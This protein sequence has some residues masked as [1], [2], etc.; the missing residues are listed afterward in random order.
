MEILSG[1]I[2]K[3]R[4]LDE[5]GRC[6]LE[7]VD[8]GDSAQGLIDIILAV[9]KEIVIPDASCARVGLSDFEDPRAVRSEDIVVQ[10]EQGSFPADGQAA[11]RWVG[12]CRAIE[13]IGI[14][15][16]LVYLGLT[17]NRESGL[18]VH[19]GVIDNGEITRR[20]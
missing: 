15:K 16:A 9:R 19:E 3:E 13:G 20:V 6:V 2:E 18:I 7:L 12:A 5:I 14:I 8:V 11:K 17:L 10:G 1:G 4:I